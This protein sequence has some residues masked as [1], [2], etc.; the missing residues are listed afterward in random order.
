VQQGNFNNY[1]VLRIDEMPH[2]EVHIVPSTANSGGIGEASTPG[3]APAVTNAIFA[4]TGQR[5]RTLPIV[6]QALR[7]P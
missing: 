4:A 2:V 7:L 5:I 6:G 3:I 1:D